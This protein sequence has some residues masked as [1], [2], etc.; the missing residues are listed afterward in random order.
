M[1]SLSKQTRAMRRRMRKP[2]GLK[3]RQYADNFIDL[4]KYLDL[5]PGSTMSDKIGVTELNEILLNSMPNIWIKQAY[6]QWF[7]CGSITIK[8][9]LTFLN[10]WR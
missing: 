4:N 8:N 7:F 1:N 3:V 9:L 5:F 6:L 2:C 10:S